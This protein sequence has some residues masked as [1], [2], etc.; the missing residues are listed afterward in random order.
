MYKKK[1]GQNFLVNQNVSKKILFNEKITKRNILEIGTGNLA[2]SKF[3]ISNQ[4]KKFLGVEVDRDLSDIYLKNEISDKIIF[5]DA[6]KINERKFFNNENF[7]II[8]NLPFNISSEL[9]I[10]WCKIQNSYNCID[11]MVLM[12]QKEL[13]ERIIAK[14]D[15]KKFGRLTIICNAFFSIKKKLLVSKNNFFPI[16]KVDAMVLNFIPHKINKIK[17]KN[18]E[19]LEKI[20][21]IFF[22]ERRKINK[23]KIIKNFSVS[24]IKKYNLENL[25]NLRAENIDKEIFFKLSN[26]L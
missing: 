10:K 24:K 11:S 25:Y 14:K 13:A 6:L 7:S 4:P 15:T 16:P 17:K 12:F 19:K 3:I 8:S 22:N 18:F 1:Y 23:K 9:V 2:L 20:T 21:R 5:E 26:I